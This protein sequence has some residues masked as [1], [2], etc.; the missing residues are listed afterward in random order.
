MDIFLTKKKKEK[1]KRKRK[2]RIVFSPPEVIM[3]ELKI[4]CSKFLV[5]VDEPQLS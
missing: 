5:V 1:E 3:L 2:K 4:L